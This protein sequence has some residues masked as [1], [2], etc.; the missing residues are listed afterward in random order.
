MYG[1]SIE[2]KSL[3]HFCERAVQDRTKLYVIQL[4]YMHFLSDFK[5]VNLCSHY[6][7]TIERST[8]K[9]YVLRLRFKLTSVL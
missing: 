8:M 4:L 5:L 3:C 7:E 2:N 9:R 1:N 6:K